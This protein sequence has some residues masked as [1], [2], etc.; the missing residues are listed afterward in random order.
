I[1]L[2]KREKDTL[3]TEKSYLQTEVQGYRE[4]SSIASRTVSNL[5]DHNKSLDSQIIQLKGDLLK[6]IHYTIFLAWS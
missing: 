2:L 3:Q 6:G 1:D 4:K 5:N